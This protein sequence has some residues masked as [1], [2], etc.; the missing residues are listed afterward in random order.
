M[1]TLASHYENTY[2]PISFPKLIL[3]KEMNYQASF[4]SFISDSKKFAFCLILCK[5]S[6]QLQRYSMYFLSFSF[7]I[8]TGSLSGCAYWYND[9][10]YFSYL[11]DINAL[12]MDYKYFFNFSFTF[13]LRFDALGQL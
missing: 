7:S 9:L 12:Y 6:Y 1:D 11:M 2:F 4:G 8:Q 5:F 3:S 10:Y 13:Y